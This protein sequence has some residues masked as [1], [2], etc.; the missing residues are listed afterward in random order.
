MKVST[1]TNSGFTL[2]EV[3][4]ATAVVVLV[5]ITI[6][7]GV[8]Y[9]IKNT[10]FSREKLKSLHYATESIEWL[11]LQRDTLGWQGFSSQLAALNI[12]PGAVAYLCVP[13]ITSGTEATS[14]DSLEIATITTQQ[15]GGYQQELPNAESRCGY[16]VTGSDE[17]AVYENTFR[18]ELQLRYVSPQ[19]VEVESRVTWQDGESNYDTTL[20]SAIWDWE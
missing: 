8:S 11:R 2:I 14:L 17:E 13:S 12:V 4:V 10:R 9:S 15:G 16:V 19:Q 1:G 3:M 7:T 20:R 5:M 6:S 18:R